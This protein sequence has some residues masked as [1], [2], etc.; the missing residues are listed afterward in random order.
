MFGPTDNRLQPTTWMMDYVDEPMSNT[1]EEPTP[2][3][4]QIDVEMDD[5]LE[6]NMDEITTQS[7]GPRI[8]EAHKGRMRLLLDDHCYMKNTPNPKKIKC[9]YKREIQIS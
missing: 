3:N 2:E 8:V 5:C 1:V 4:L 6:D 9:K 7:D